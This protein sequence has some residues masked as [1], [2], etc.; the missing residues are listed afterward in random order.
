M[1]F[2]FQKN[3]SSIFRRVGPLEL[4]DPHRRVALGPSFLMV[5]SSSVI[6][7]LK[8]FLSLL[9]F[10]RKSVWDDLP[11]YFSSSSIFRRVGPL[12]LP[13]PH[14]RV[15]LAFSFRMVASSPVIGLLKLFRRLLSFFEGKPLFPTDLCVAF[16]PLRL[17]FLRISAWPS[18][19]YACLSRCCW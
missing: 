9:S 16:S 5:P 13:D 8:L 6:D 10:L 7:I 11:A 18:V 12:Q 3:L 2:L 14:H 1:L 4:Q 19:L 17:S 15:D